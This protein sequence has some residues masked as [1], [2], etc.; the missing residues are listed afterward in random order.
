VRS[1]TCHHILSLVVLNR[2]LYLP[3]VASPSQSLQIL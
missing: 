1:F 3:K 2:K